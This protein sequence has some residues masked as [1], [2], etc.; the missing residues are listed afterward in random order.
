MES[1][2]S[3]TTYFVIHQSPRFT[4]H[5]GALPDLST[6]SGPD[7]SASVLYYTETN[8][9]KTKIDM[10][11]ITTGL[12]RYHGCGSYDELHGAGSP[13]QPWQSRN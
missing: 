7:G 6:T 4:R 5:N 8:K 12:L 11:R 9:E 10:A 13:A 3:C 1:N 2:H